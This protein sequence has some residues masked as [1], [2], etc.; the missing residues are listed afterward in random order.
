MLCT[1][2]AAA[3][4]AS[5][6]QDEHRVTRSRDLLQAAPAP[7]NDED[8]AA[9]T[10]PGV[11]DDDA[12]DDGVPG[13]APAVEGDDGADDGGDDGAAP[14]PAE[15]DDGADDGGDDIAPAASPEAATGVS[16]DDTQGA[17]TNVGSMGPIAAVAG[18]TTL[19][20]AALA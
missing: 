10:G 3:G 16:D 7:A 8:D 4:S 17:L 12:E 14:A 1:A 2:L 5:A 15:G 6:L 20:V 13:A 19:L 18:V 9:G 11:N